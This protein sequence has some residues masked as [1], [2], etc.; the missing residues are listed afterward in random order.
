MFERSASARLRAV[1]LRPACWGEQRKGCLFA[2]RAGTR[3]SGRLLWFLSWRRKKGTA[4]PAATSPICASNCIC[5][6]T[7]R[8]VGVAPTA[9]RGAGH[10]LILPFASLGH[11]SAQT[12]PTGVMRTLPRPMGFATCEVFLLPRYASL[13]ST[14][15]M[16]AKR[17]SASLQSS[18]SVR[19]FER[20]S[21]RRLERS[22]FW[23]G[24]GRRA[25]QGM[26]ARAAGRHE[27]FGPPSLV[28]FLA[29]QERNSQPSNEATPSLAEW[30]CDFPLHRVDVEPTSFR[31]AGHRLM[32]RCAHKTEA[33][34]RFRRR[35]ISRSDVKRAARPKP[36]RL[37]PAPPG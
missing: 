18:D 22:E 4:N 36:N 8:R 30:I 24:P 28:P 1:S 19:L 16:G 7:L 11:K 26:P 34:R 29:A 5:G 27:A 20:S 10:R 12:R 31:R 3:H 21:S 23:T 35:L 14:A 25:A 17:A 15:A 32:L 6:F 37:K 9:F 2:Q 33:Q 13:S